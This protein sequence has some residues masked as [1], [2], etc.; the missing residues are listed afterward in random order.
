MQQLDQLT[1]GPGPWLHGW[2]M[3]KQGNVR[4]MWQKINNDD[5]PCLCRILLIVILAWDFGS[6]GAEV[7][8]KKK[9]KEGKK[10]DRSFGC[11]HHHRL[12]LFLASSDCREYEGN[13]RKYQSQEVYIFQLQAR[14]ESFKARSDLPGKR[15]QY[16]AVQYSRGWMRC[17]CQSTVKRRKVAWDQKIMSCFQLC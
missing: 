1:K 16:S 10:A 12:L 5:L 11:M 7:C 9:K 17:C 8:L 4:H 3:V 14:G 6:V 2:D 15:S 13:V